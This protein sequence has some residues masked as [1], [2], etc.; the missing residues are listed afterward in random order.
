L[1][2]LEM[3]DRLI[4]ARKT[5]QHLQMT[6]VGARVVVEYQRGRYVEVGRSR[7]RLAGIPTVAEVYRQFVA[8]KRQG[9]ALTQSR[10]YTI[11]GLREWDVYDSFVRGFITD[12]TKPAGIRTSNYYAITTCRRCAYD[13]TC[14]RHQSSIA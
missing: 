8:E 13:S 14:H 10:H 1:S 12:T 9:A 5:P 7:R 4:R 11:N 6:S 2:N 3:L